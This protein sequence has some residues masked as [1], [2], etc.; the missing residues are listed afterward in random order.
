MIRRLQKSRPNDSEEHDDGL[1]ADTIRVCN[2]KFV[3]KLHA[4]TGPCNRCWALASHEDREK[5]K[6]RGSNLR[7]TKTRSGCDRTCTIFPPDDDG[8]PVRLCRQC[9]FATHQQQEGCKLQVY[10]GNHIKM[11]PMR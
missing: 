5:Y 1:S 8:E 7:I 6:I 10:R 3:Y 11:R 9:F 2:N 4:K